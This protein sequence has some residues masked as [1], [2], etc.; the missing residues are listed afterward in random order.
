MQSLAIILISVIRDASQTI[1]LAEPLRH[2]GGCEQNWCEVQ[3]SSQLF[4]TKL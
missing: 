2:D 3:I 1:A 4:K